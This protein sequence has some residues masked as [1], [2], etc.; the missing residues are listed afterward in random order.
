MHQKCMGFREEAAGQPRQTKRNKNAADAASTLPPELLVG[1]ADWQSIS[2]CPAARTLSGWSQ[3]RGTLVYI[4]TRCKRWTCPHCGRRRITSLSRKVAKAE[5][6]KFVTLTI[7][8]GQYQTPA[9]AF[10][11]TSRKVAPLVTKLR[12]LYGPIEY[13]KVTEATKAGWPHFHLCMAAG[14][15]PQATI[16]DLWQG[17]TG[18][19]IVDIRQVK[20]VRDVY[21]YMVKYLAKQTAVP[22]T[23]RRV[24]WTRHFFDNCPK[25]EGLK[26]ELQG[27]VR[28]KW[29]PQAVME[30][31][32]RG[33]LIRRLTAD[34]WELVPAGETIEPFDGDEWDVRTF[35]GQSLGTL[36]AQREPEGTP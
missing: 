26:L 27:V 16:S 14:Y 35:A 4:Q 28:E 23:K 18:A 29:H 12:R 13:L 5:P 9:E 2:W 36:P 20:K 33:K 11:A 17:L 8:P 19:H 30:W 31:Q 7:D 25:P 10:A 15:I 34:A 32:Q 22:W 24:S 3:T 6:S 21:W 1:S